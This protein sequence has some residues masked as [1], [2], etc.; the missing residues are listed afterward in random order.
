MEIEINP[1]IR[2]KALYDA[3]Q[4]TPTS[5]MRGA[6][7]SRRTAFRY[8]A[9]FKKED[10]HERP[11]IQVRKKKKRTSKLEKKVI[12]K[13]QERKRIWSTREIGSSV[14]VSHTT[15]QL[16]LRENKIKYQRYNRQLK[17]TK[18]NVDKRLQFARNMKRRE[19]DWGFVMFTDECSFWKENTKPNRLWTN[20]PLNEEGTGTHGIKV[21]CWGAIS[22]LGALPI[23]IFEENLTARTYINIMQQALPQINLLYPNGFIWQQDGSGVHRAK[24]VEQFIYANMPQTLDWPSYSPDLSPMEN[25]WSWIKGQVAKDCPKTLK[26]L[27]TSIRKH[28]SSINEDFLASYINSMPERMRLVIKNGGGKINY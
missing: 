15:V 24:T 17:L 14:G 20:D 8:L 11:E 10:P 22:A 26:A 27:K 28:W 23:R 7:V 12:R 25:I 2:A 4:R 13:A 18:E 9:E 16:I 3:N 19:C 6:Q 5:I 21:H 1:K